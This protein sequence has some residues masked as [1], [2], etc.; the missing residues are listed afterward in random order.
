MAAIGSS[1]DSAYFQGG[2]LGV[3]L[4]DAIVAFSDTG[5][6]L[7]LVDK[8]GRPNADTI[9][10][11]KYNFGTHKIQAADVTATAEGTETPESA[12]TTEKVTAT[13]DMLSVNV[14]LYDEADIS[15]ADDI[16]SNIGELVGNALAAKV[17]TLLAA[18]MDGFATSKGTSSVAITVDNIFSALQVLKSNGALGQLSCVLHP[19]QVWGD[20]GLTNSMIT[21][22]QFG[23]VLAA[24]DRFAERGEIGTF[25]G[26]N[27]YSTR[28]LTPSS[29]A[30]KGGMFEKRALGFGYGHLTPKGNSVVSPDKLFRIE[31]V[32]FGTYIRDNLVGVIFGKEKVVEDTL[33]VEIW[34][35]TS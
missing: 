2:L 26:I 3:V 8:V 10:W 20:N 29:S 21:T 7:P 30:V 18:A 14:P 12:L 22:T 19:E 31:Q 28:N 4:A 27:F 5:V 9:S 24:Q 11:V 35:K 15:N 13:L 6:M 33:G 1:S 16:S 17:D 23:G 34:T 25:A 32:R